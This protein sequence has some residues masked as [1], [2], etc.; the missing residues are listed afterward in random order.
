L[1]LK[2]LLLTFLLLLLSGCGR[3]KGNTLPTYSGE[4]NETSPQ[5][6]NQTVADVNRTIAVDNFINDN[7]CD[8]LLEKEFS[9]GELL[10]ICYDYTYKSAKYV[11]YHLDG[12]LVN[13]ENIDTRPS[14]Y[15]ERDI[16]KE[17][18]SYNGDYIRSGYDRG[19]LAPDADFDYNNE[20]LKIIYTFANIIPQDPNVNRYFW[21]KAE[22]QERLVAATLGE[23]N[24]INGV[25][26]SENPDHIGEHN[27]AVPKGF[28]K[29]LWN[30]DKKFRQCYYYDNFVLGDADLDSLDKHRVACNKL[31]VNAED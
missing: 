30:D 22:Y 6:S 28:W 1:K 18:R 17:Y 20:D 24:V 5:D 13:E 21:T 29:I 26:F 16:P 3:T 12:A 27:I 25:E 7:N 11:A 4:R 10:S 31:I 14:F 9:T 8:Q 19:H 15:T 2:A 23:L